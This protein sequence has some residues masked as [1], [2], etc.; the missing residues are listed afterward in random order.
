MTSSSQTLD[1]QE[2]KRRLFVE[3]RRLEPDLAE[4][5]DTQINR[6]CFRSSSGVRLSYAGFRLLCKH[7]ENHRFELDKPLIMRELITLSRTAQ[8]PHFLSDRYLHI[9]CSR[10][11]FLIKLKG[12]VHQWL[13]H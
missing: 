3:L 5:S 8:W 13:S 1:I 4:L 9:F 10:D 6:R 7:F 12:G 11:V 2:I